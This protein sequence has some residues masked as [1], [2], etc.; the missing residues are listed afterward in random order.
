M[1]CHA[2]N[3][4]NRELYCITKTITGKEGRQEVGMKDQQKVAHLLM[5]FMPK[6]HV[7]QHQQPVLSIRTSKWCFYLNTRKT[8]EVDEALQ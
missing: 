2:E 6:W 3:G 4:K 5:P 8:A 1:L 7:G